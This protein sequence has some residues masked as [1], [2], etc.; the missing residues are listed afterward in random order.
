MS[1]PCL[2]SLYTPTREKKSSIKIDPCLA[3]SLRH[4]SYTTLLLC[5]KQNPGE[6]W[7]WGGNSYLDGSEVLRRCLKIARIPLLLLIRLL[8]SGLIWLLWGLVSI[9]RPSRNHG[10]GT[11]DSC[12]L[13]IQIPL[14]SNGFFK[15][16]LVKIFSLS[17]KSGRENANSKKFWKLHLAKICQHFF[18]QNVEFQNSLIKVTCSL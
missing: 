4:E 8:R 17:R 9:L 14:I 7:R 16:R 10:E 1:K 6:I 5:C 2:V 3:L 11:A 12:Q 15:Y 13:E 18:N